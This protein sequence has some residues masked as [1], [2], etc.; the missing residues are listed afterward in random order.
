[1]IQSVRGTKDIL[2]DDAGNWQFVEKKFAEVSH[3]YGYK[4][5]RTPLFERTEVFS[6]GIGEG[7]DIVNKEM[8]TF[9]DKGGD[10]LTLRPEMTASLVRAVVQNSLLHDSPI[11]RLWYLGPFFRYER[12]QKGRL[13]QF[14]Q[15]GAEC[16]GS[17]NPEADAEVILLANSLFRSVGITNYKLILNTLGTNETRNNYLVDL[18]KYLQSYKDKLSN[19]SRNRLEFNPLRI[20][21]SK[22]DDDLKILE[23]API[24]LDFLDDESRNHFEAVKAL[25]VNAGLNYVTEPKLVR[26]LDYY[27]H[28]VFEFQSSILGAQDS[29]GGGG[30]YNNLIEQFGGP[31]TPAVGFALG[32]ERIL[33]IIE[34]SN[35]AI[36]SDSNEQIYIVTANHDY[37]QYSLNI[38][39]KLRQRNLRVV[40]DLNRRSIKSQMKEANKN[41]V[42]YV[43]II[44]EDE[45]KENSVT[46]KN[47]QNSEQFKL[48][49]DSIENYNFE[50]L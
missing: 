50:V 31:P 49:L 40:L 6:R 26:G 13:R 1:M 2:P 25:L 9:T 24:I 12:P 38:A 30:R 42:K 41:N 11:I 22:Y 16:I 33:M 29:F 19:D 3:C 28:T 23:N 21:D 39:D 46:I 17:P 8:Y 32:I 4:E 43:V 47:M 7:T 35:T 27:N 37:I 5:I 18:V 34:Q 45:I 44:G 14:H 36:Q 15:Y 48:P 10:S 20:L